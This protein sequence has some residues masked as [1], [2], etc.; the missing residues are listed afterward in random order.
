[1]YIHLTFIL[2]KKINEINIT[3]KCIDERQK[4]VTKMIECMDLQSEIRKKYFE[5]KF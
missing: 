3:R 5:I 1:M 4:A 2:K